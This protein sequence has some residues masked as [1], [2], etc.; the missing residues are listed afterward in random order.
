MRRRVLVTTTMSMAAAASIALAMPATA[1]AA[2]PP[3]PPAVP[4]PLAD[5]V[6]NIVQ[7]ILAAL[8]PGIVH[9]R[10]PSSQSGSASSTASG[11]MFRYDPADTCI[12]CTN[13]EAGPGMASSGSQVIRV[14]GQDISAGQSSAGS[15]NSGDVAALP[16]N[17]LVALVL[18]GWMASADSSQTGS[19]AH[20]QSS[21]V[22]L[23][24]ADGRV[25]TIGVIESA[26][27]T[28][29]NPS[30][31]Q[32]DSA[33]NGATANAGQ[34][35]LVVILLHAD[36]SSSGHGDAYLASVNGTTFG[37]SAQTGGG[38]GIAVPG[39]GTITLLKV[40]GTGGQGGAQGGTA[41]DTGGQSGNNARA[42]SASGSSSPKAWNNQSGSGAQRPSS[43]AGGGA[44]ESPN[45]ASGSLGLGA[46]SAGAALGVGGFILLG[47]GAA[48]VR[49]AAY[50]R[51][52]GQQPLLQ[53]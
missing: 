43:I 6:P 23:S 50:R 18:A 17:P 34:G 36:G 1:A 51:R 39:A 37:S 15:S 52:S 49:V 47:V 35:M 40:G 20:A 19:A 14:N 26:S 53:T 31:S 48:L 10:P 8:P 11:D 3:T 25:A 7:Q 13:A 2:A 32:G 41:T 45:A 38:V 33:T 27:N 22:N 9:S 12:G 5:A 16:A 24:L 44:Q 21:L 30:S 4:A 29:A 28:T 46:P 42:F